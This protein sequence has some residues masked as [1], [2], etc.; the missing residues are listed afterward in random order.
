MLQ[1]TQ[2]DRVIPKY[3]GFIKTFP[4]F[5]ALAKA[6]L[7]DVLKL[8]IG[9]GYNRR[10]KFL[11]QSA[12]IIVKKFA[13]KLPEETELLETLPGIGPATAASLATF[14]YNKPTI[15]LETNVRAVLIHAFFK[16]HEKVDDKKLYILAEQVLDTKNPQRWYNALMDYGAMLKQTE[17]HTRKST[18]YTKQSKF[19]GSAREIRGKIIR[20]LTEKTL[21]TKALRKKINDTRLERIIADLQAESL[22]VQRQGKF[23]LG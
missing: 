20:M 21:T 1:Q 23:S 2:V 5:K 19:K 9:L 6:S 13:G 18:A 8:W 4:S 22:I 16:N 12:E 17:N 14:A 10:A 15:F 3:L 7:T 11:K